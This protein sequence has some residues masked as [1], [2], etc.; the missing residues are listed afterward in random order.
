M[1]DFI[2]ITATE[3]VIEIAKWTDLLAGLGEKNDSNRVLH[4]KEFRSRK[5]SERNHG[6]EI[7]W[8]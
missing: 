8:R 7:S 3:S 2:D 5:Q 4:E 1:Y 6:N